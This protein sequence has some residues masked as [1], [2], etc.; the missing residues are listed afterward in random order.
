MW[1]SIIYFHLSI[2]IMFG[3]FEFLA[4]IVLL[5]CVIVYI[6]FKDIKK[7]LW[8]YFKMDTYTDSCKR[9]CVKPKKADDGNCYHPVEYNEFLKINQEVRSELICPWSCTS[10]YSDD[11]HTCQYDQDCSGCSPTA[12]FPSIDDA[13]PTSTYGCCADKKTVRTDKFGNNCLTGGG[14]GCT[15]ATGTTGYHCKEAFTSG[16]DSR[17]IE[18]SG[19]TDTTQKTMDSSGIDQNLYI[20]KTTLVPQMYPTCPN[21]KCP[22]ESAFNKDSSSS[23]ATESNLGTLPPHPWP[24]ITDYTSFGI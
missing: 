4:V 24:V 15:G 5:F 16:S 22:N 7:D 17:D 6:I 23:A 10:G 3:F 13:C 12:S 18:T 19:S 21:I 1:C 11:P 20:L 14:A 8:K 9:K 2:Y